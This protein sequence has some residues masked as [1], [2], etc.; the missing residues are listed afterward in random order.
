[1]WTLKHST[2]RDCLGFLIAGRARF[3]IIVECGGERII[4]ETH[5]TAPAE[6]RPSV[7]RAACGKDVVAKLSRPS[8]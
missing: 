8:N 2:L 5:L 4:P 1:M 3:R 7:H 6:H